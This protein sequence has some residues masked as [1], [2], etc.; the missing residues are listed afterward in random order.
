MHDFDSQGFLIIKVKDK[1]AM[2]YA[3]FIKDATSKS[4]KV[5]IKARGGRIKTA[6]DV[7]Q[8]LLNKMLLVPWKVSVIIGSEKSPLSDQYNKEIKVSTIEISMEAT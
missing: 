2:D 4:G 1:T 6:V 7:S 8:I 5:R 3:N